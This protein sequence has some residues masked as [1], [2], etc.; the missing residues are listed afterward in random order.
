MILKHS[1]TFQVLDLGKIYSD[2]IRPH[3]YYEDLRG[4]VPIYSDCVRYAF[5]KEIDSIAKATYRI[6]LKK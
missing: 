4:K 6:N 2:T 5:S 1:E 3:Q